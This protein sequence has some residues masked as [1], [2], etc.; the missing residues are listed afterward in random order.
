MKETSETAPT[1]GFRLN[2]KVF[3]PTKGR[4]ETTAKQTTKPRIE[5]EIIKKKDLPP[6][7]CHTSSNN[8][9]MMSKALINECTAAAGGRP[10]KLGDTSQILV[11]K[12]FKW[13][14][15]LMSFTVPKDKQQIWITHAIRSVLSIAGVSLSN[16]IASVELGEGEPNPHQWT[17]VSFTKEAYDAF[18]EIRLLFD[19]RSQSAVSVREWTMD[20]PRTQIFSIGAVVTSNDSEK[21]AA[22]AIKSLEETIS[23]LVKEA[24]VTVTRTAMAIGPKSGLVKPVNVHLCIGDSVKETFFIDP[25][26]FRGLKIHTPK[27]TRISSCRFGRL[28]PSCASDSHVEKK[29]CPWISY[30]FGEKRINF[31]IPKDTVPG[32]TVEPKIEPTRKRKR[33]DQGSDIESLKPNPMPKMRDARPKPPPTKRQKMDLK[34][35][36][37]ATSDNES[38]VMPE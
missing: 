20:S 26:S 24:G 12:G 15:K 35:K 34:G 2:V 5:W 9:D 27:G 3:S 8:L 31:D 13:L 33:G 6:E 18:T 19:P 37:R 4:T 7:M 21:E 32:R 36:G 10:H 28:C 1:G 17:L 38:D 25:E 30:K 16:M 14:F 11:E 29:E 22:E 23:D